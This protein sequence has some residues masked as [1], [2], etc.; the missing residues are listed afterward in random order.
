MPAAAP[1]QRKTIRLS[2]IAVGVCWPLSLL[3]R[4]LMRCLT[5][6]DERWQPIHLLIVR[7]RHMLWARL[8]VLR[9]W[10]WLWL[11]LLRIERL[12][13]ARREWLAA[14]RRLFVVSIV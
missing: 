14:N 3:R 4:R 9:L 2:V 13:F 10:L 7:L 12:W 11:L 6:G 5:A 8:K 1:M